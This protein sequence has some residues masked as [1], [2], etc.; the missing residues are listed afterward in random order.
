MLRFCDCRHFG[1]IVHQAWHGRCRVL[2]RNVGYVMEINC[3]LA[4]YA[5]LM[6]GGAAG[7]V[8]AALLAM[9]ARRR[10]EDDSSAVTSVLNSSPDK[11]K[12]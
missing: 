8:L 9:A 5:A 1:L 7:M 4:V 12:G 11:L 2:N 6:L 10:D 3:W